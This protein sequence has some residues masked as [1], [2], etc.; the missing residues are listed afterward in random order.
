MTTLPE[1]LSAFP[2]LPDWESRFE[3]L[4]ELGNVLPPMPAA[5]RT[6]ENK[7]RGCTSQVWMLV[8]W[9]GTGD[10]AKLN[11]HVDSDAMIVRGLLALVWLAYNGKTRAEMA[12][13]DLPAL[14]NPTGLL[15]QL[16]PNRRN[17]FASVLAT[18]KALANP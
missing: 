9:N 11:L 7:V 1:A 2:L 6:E 16:S 12:E 3:H 17:G 8:G 14:L 5:L 18:L 15:G 13:I 10:G 4:I